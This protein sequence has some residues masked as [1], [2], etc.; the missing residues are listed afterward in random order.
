[1]YVERLNLINFRNYRELSLDLAEGI[2]LIVGKNGQG[3]TNLLEGLYF[4]S[5]FR[6]RPSSR[7]ADLCYQG[8]P[9]FTVGAVVYSGFRKSR[10]GAMFGRGIKKII[11]D[12]VEKESISEVRGILKTVMFSP[13]DTLVISGEPHLRRTFLD[14]IMELVDPKYGIHMRAY[15]HALLQRNAILSKWEKYGDTLHAALE[16]WNVVLAE[17]GPYLIEKRMDFLRLA[18]GVLR[19]EYPLLSGK[20]MDVSVFYACSAGGEDRDT[21]TVVSSEAYLRSLYESINEDLRARCT[22]RGPHRDDFIL[23][24]SGKDARRFMSQGEKR[25]AAYC[26]RIAETRYIIEK[27]GEKPVLMLDDVMS[28]LDSGRIRRLTE[29]VFPADQVIVTDTSLERAC[30]FSHSR[31]IEVEGGAA[32]L[33]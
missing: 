3:K 29:A 6:A 31:V 26:L 30:E 16:P 22:T 18:D 2:N 32:R 5:R 4:I 27:A 11:L 13:E 8:Q 24:L 1:M 15:R 19:K 17:S 10:I 9:Y 25:T 28:E 7:T 33:G 21:G 23:L 12:G 20:E 14:S